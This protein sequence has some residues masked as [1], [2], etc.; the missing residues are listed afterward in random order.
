MTKE[1]ITEWFSVKEM[2]PPI[3]EIVKLYRHGQTALC[4]CDRKE[5]TW[6]WAM[7]LWEGVRCVEP[8]D[9]WAFLDD[10]E[11]EDENN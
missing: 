8:T 1:T 6:Y 7:I 2:L 9:M 11:L 10:E 3:G 4:L 5:S